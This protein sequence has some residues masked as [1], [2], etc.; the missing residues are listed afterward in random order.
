[1]KFTLP[2]KLIGTLGTIRSR[3]G[4]NLDYYPPCIRLNNRPFQ[5]RFFFK[6]LSLKLHKLV[7][8]RRRM[9]PKTSL[10]TPLK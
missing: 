7:F 8:F 10:Q 3:C 5:P 4:N 1:M 9:K 2:Y 6:F